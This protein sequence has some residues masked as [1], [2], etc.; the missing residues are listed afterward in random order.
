MPRLAVGIG[1]WIGCRSQSPVHLPAVGQGRRPVDRGAQQ[2]MT[3]THPGTQ[4]DQPRILGSDR[5]IRSDAEPLGSAPQQGHLTDRLRC[6]REQEPLR[7]GRKRPELSHEGLFNAARQRQRTGKPEAAGQLRDAQPPGQLQ[8]R[9]RV[10]AGLGDDA[11]PHPL[12]QS[13]RGHRVEQ[14][15]G[16]IAVQALDRQQWQ[17]PK[18]PLLPGLSQ[19]EHQCD[20]F[21]QQAARGER[22]CLRRSLIEPLRI[23]DQAHQ[24]PLLSR[25]RQQPEHRQTDQQAIRRLPRAQAED[26][27]QRIALRARQSS[28]TCP[29][30][31]RRAAA[32]QQ[33][34]APSR[35]QRPPLAQR[36]TR[37]PARARSPATRSCRLPLRRARPEPAP[38]PRLSQQPVQGLT[39]G[40]PVTQSSPSKTAG[41]RH[42][43]N[44]ASPSLDSWV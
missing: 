24:R 21:R 41:H 19:R 15:T 22:Q 23:I 35:T 36:G 33:T 34:R 1:T 42:H 43:G 6:R 10:A 8:Q 29:A 17:A 30:T 7:P 9:Q 16:V 38:G 32:G 2:R 11:V 13:P 4:L 20:R 5:S 3:E 12:I 14:R 39:L 27:V 37:T 18:L 28:Q 25:L 40:P 26:R 44:S 31:A